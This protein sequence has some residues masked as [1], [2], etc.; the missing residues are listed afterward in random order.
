ME[1]K[2]Y[3]YLAKRWWWLLLLMTLLGGGAALGASVLQEPVYEASTTVLINQAPGALP[4]AESV[5][6]GQRVAATYAELMLQRPVL[7]AVITNLQLNITP[8][9]L[10]NQVTVTPVRDTN[11]LVVSVRDTEPGR[12]AAKANEIV[13][14]FIE[15][16]IQYQSS[17]YAAS[18]A[19]LQGEM[20]K[21]QAELAQTEASL[22]SLEGASTDSAIAERI[23]LQDHL[24]ENQQT[25]ASLMQSYEEI[26]LAEAQ[27]TDKVNVVETALPGTSQTSIPR[28]TLL[29]AV[30]GMMIGAGAVFLI[31]YLRETVKTDAEV[32][33]LVG[34]P[35]LGIVHQI[36]ANGTGSVAII[37]ASKPRSSYAEAYRVLRA[38]I[39]FATI[40]KPP[41]SIVVTSSGPSEG[42]TTTAANLAIAIAQSGK[43]V[44]LVDAD[45]RRPKLHQ[46]FQQP[47]NYGITSALLHHDGELVVSHIIPTEVDNLFLLPSG[48][49]P[50]NPA[51]LLASRRMAQLIQELETHL[52]CIIFDTPPVLAVA[53]SSL[54]ARLCDATLLVVQAD[55]T[56]TQVLRRA[57]DQ[58]AQSG[59]HLLGVVLNRVP[60]T[61]NG[62]YY[63]HYYQ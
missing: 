25:Y 61:S 54:L 4:T 62:Y 53:D 34:A 37:T 15:Q 13:N 33:Q 26:R 52:D 51:D 14:V 19:A 18:L 35:T 16:N 10:E 30:V 44:L 46:V 9:E 27:T 45:L 8:G 32:E 23:R 29:G 57:T 38:N 31:E 21:L 17:R 59:A 40:D 7:E 47:N 58:I 55:T 50:P 22:E 60:S 42:K 36:K 49:L 3:L 41:R 24:S 43:R 63:Y 48:P 2:Q 56:R 12:A 28:N 11:L 6:A 39:D 1:L 5:L 20:E